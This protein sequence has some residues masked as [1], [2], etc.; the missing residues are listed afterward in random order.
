M[1]TRNAATTNLGK[2]SVRW[3]DHLYAPQIYMLKS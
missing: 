1:G 3:S 2:E